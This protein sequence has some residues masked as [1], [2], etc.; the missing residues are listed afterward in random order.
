MEVWDSPKPQQLLERK[1]V[2]SSLRC[3]EWKTAPFSRVWVVLCFAFTRLVVAE[4][5]QAIVGAAVLEVV[6]VNV[7][8]DARHRSRRTAGRGGLTHASKREQGGEE[9]EKERS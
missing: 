1:R 7:A 9:E 5:R 6:H 2:P 8:A 4:A 3:D